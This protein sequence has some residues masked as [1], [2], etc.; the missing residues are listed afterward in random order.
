MPSPTEYLWLENVLFFALATTFFVV[1]GW[2]WRHSKPFSIPQPL[3]SWFKLWLSIVLVVGVILP[4]FAML[5]WGVW[6]AQQSVLQV[7]L[8]YFVMLGLQILSESVIA[9]RFQSCIWVTIPCLYLPYR[10]WQLYSGL[11]LLSLEDGVTWV[12]R[13]LIVEIILWIFNYGVHLS[14]IPKLMRWETLPE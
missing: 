5:Y 9:K 13:I 10:I 1:G 6:Q 3:P 14:Q 7:L 12:Q 4:L 11:T 8:S 2:M